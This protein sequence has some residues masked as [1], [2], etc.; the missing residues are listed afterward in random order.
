[1][2]WR[3]AAAAACCFRSRKPSRARVCCLSL[4]LCLAMLH[5]GTHPQALSC[6]C[7][8]C[9]VCLLLQKAFTRE[10]VP[11]VLVKDV[12]LYE[13]V[14]VKDVLAYVRCVPDGGVGIIWGIRVS[15]GQDGGQTIWSHILGGHETSACMNVWR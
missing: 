8:C 14:E 15:A 9:L 13:R 12:S 11:F 4:C 5:V 6:C 3:A 10:G 1:M 2:Y 7:C